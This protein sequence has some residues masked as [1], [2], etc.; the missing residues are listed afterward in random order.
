MNTDS[1]RERCHPHVFEAFVS[2]LQLFQE[3]RKAEADLARECG[4][5][6]AS[7][8][9]LLQ[10]SVPAQPSRGRW[11]VP[12]GVAHNLR[13]CGSTAQSL[14]TFVFSCVCVPRRAQWFLGY[15]S[16]AVKQIAVTAAY[17]A[18]FA[19][20]RAVMMHGPMFA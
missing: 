1:V 18:A 9:E 16:P 19:R 14:L 11:R 4:A 6:L 20:Q 12:P 8:G 13:V 15:L 2:S 7:D 3:G 5:L 17:E 10:A